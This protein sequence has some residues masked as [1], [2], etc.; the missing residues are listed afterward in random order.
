MSISESVT[1]RH[2]LGASVAAG[3]ALA[4]AQG[5]A[6]R[7]EG[8]GEMMAPL[9]SPLA[10]LPS[11]FALRLSPFPLHLSP[12]HWLLVGEASILT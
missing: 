8:R 2:F 3:A 5:R 11:L 9:S 1:R 10:L 12:T 7:G 4:V 6:T